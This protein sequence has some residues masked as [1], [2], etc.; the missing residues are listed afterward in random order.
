MPEYKVQPGD[1]LTGIAARHEV[2]VSDIKASNDIIGDINHIESGW[3]LNIP[4]PEASSTCTMPPSKAANDV[5]TGEASSACGVEYAALLHL[6]DEPDTVYALTQMQLDEIDSEIKTL[7]EPLIELKHKEEGPEADIPAAR[8]VAW[9]KLKELGALP[10]PKKSSTAEELLNQYEAK[11]ALERRRLDHQRRRHTRIRFEIDRIRE[12]IFKPIK[13]KQP[14]LSEKDRL[15]LAV[16]EAMHKELTNTL[17]SVEAT[18]EARKAAARESQGDIET[19][20]RQLKLLRAALEAEISYRIAEADSEEHVSRKEQLRVESERLKEATRWPGYIA[21]SDIRTLTER[22]K[23]LNQLDEER[24]P[25]WDAITSFAKKTSPVYWAYDLATEDEVSQQSTAQEEYKRLAVEQELMLDRLVRTSAPH[26]VD[27]L[28]TPQGGPERTLFEIKHTGTGGY[29]YV[30]RE[31]A[32]Q[33][34]KNWRP[35]K[36]ADVRAAMTSGELERAVGEAKQGLKTSKSLKMTLAQWQS[37]EDNFFNQLEV[38]LINASAA[39]EDGRF[40][41]DAE[42]QMFRFAAKAGLSAGYDE[43]KQEWYV[44]GKAEAAYSLLQGQASLKAQ[45]PDA[46]GT[47][48][49]LKYADPMGGQKQLHCGF[50]RADV[51]YKIQGFVGACASLSANVKVSTSKNNV[52]MRGETNGEAFAGGT[53]S[54][55]ASF[56]VKW[57]ASYDFV[58]ESVCTAGWVPEKAD[59]EFKSLLDVKAETAVSAGIGAAFDYKVSYSEGSLV[60]YTKGNLVLGVGGGGG[61]AAELNGSQIWELVKFI[62][63]SLEQ[64]DFRFLEWIEKEAFEHITFLLKVFAVS[65]NDF[66]DLIQDSLLRVEQVWE[67]L[68]TP[69]TRV[70]D[71]ALR[72]L[73]NQ[74]LDALTPPAKAEILYI[75]TRDSSTLFSNDDPYREVGAEAAL[76]VLETI[77][78]HRELIE[79]LKRMG[80][81]DSKGDFDDLRTNYSVLMFQR[82]FKSKQSAKAEQYLR[83]LYG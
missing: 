53:V 50:V 81:G 83:N 55:E 12:L 67:N 58:K 79:V 17:P 8:E 48:L 78:S 68:M 4:G 64:S 61:V 5:S 38:E 3:L 11:W 15:T 72:I 1:T 42:A 74:H 7:Q 45:L 24:T 76:K 46:T 26:P 43:E 19:M 23:K 82:L 70:R 18:L 41:A 29:R 30:R 56:S 20:E 75:L 54:N 65:D 27:V 21:E 63:W 73:Q 31:M 16:F 14:L 9:N 71:A 47:A 52:G 25:V 80:K 22:Q 69:D 57:K 49:V 39:T 66:G 37:S 60:L 35:L 13:E 32:E 33:L 59:A 51:E 10:A 62:R 2:S 77:K 28:A 34:R 6:T 36:M 44:G 40:A